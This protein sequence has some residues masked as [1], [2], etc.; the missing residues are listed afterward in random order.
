[1]APS[2]EVA[3]VGSNEIV[4]IDQAQVNFFS[5]SSPHSPA[6]LTYAP[7]HN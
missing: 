3:V 2:K 7:Q 5:S 6:Q 1:M 4:T